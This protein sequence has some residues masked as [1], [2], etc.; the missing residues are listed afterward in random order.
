ME[1]Y[2]GMGNV[3]EK[4]AAWSVAI[5]NIE[6]YVDFNPSTIITNSFA[7]ENESVVNLMKKRMK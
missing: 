7:F 1:G 5:S 6:S 2:G 4:M 3:Y